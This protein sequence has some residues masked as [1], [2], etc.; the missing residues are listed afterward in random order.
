MYDAWEAEEDEKFSEGLKAGRLRS[1][2]SACLAKSRLGKR[3]DRPLLVNF[4]ELE[5]DGA[6][7]R[8]SRGFR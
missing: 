8:R 2:R 1:I 3:P 4:V 6:R 7:L 5:E